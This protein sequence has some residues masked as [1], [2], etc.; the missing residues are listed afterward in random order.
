MNMDISGISA[1]Y[2][3]QYKNLA[4]NKT[5]LE[6]NIKED[7]TGATDE[8][9]MDACKK[10]EAYFL[11][12]MFKEMMKTTKLTEDSSN[13]TLVEFFKDQTLQQVAADSTEQNSLGLAQSLYEQMRRNYGTAEDIVSNP[14]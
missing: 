11:E 3:D 9:L 10:F 12:Q 5:S 4:S 1:G 7:Y 14:S 6:G 13:D 8:E 2:L